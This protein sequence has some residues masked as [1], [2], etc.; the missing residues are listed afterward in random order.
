MIMTYNLIP[1]R[2]PVRMKYNL[3]PYMSSTC[4]SLY[5]QYDIY[6]IWQNETKPTL[7]RTYDEIGKKL[8][9]LERMVKFIM[10][11]KWRKLLKKVKVSRR[12]RVHLYKILLTTLA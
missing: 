1:Y 9:L 6:N 5:D 3:C 12:R 2:V 11:V 7:E 4:C 8:I 10:R